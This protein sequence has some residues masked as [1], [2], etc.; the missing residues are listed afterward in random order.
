MVLGG[1]LRPL[2]SLLAPGGKRARLSVLIYHRVLA[3]PDA[4]L[5]G[6]P[7]AMRFRWQMELLARYFNP[8][9]LSEAVRR[10][11]EETLPP[12]AVSVT[13]DDGYADNM[14]IALP[15][16]QQVGV[17]ATFFIATGYLDGGWMWNDKIIETLRRMPNGD[18]D[19]T[20]MG[21]DVYSLVNTA[22]RLA[23]IEQ[24]LAWLKYLPGE[25]RERRTQ[26]LTQHCHESFPRSLMM[27]S[28]QVRQLRQA[29]M[30]IGAH[31]HSHPIL[32]SLEQA[33]AEQEIATSKA[34]LEDLLGEP[35][36]LFAYPNGKPGKDYLQEH[37]GITQ[38]LNFEAAV[39]T[40]WGVASSRSDPWQLPRFT[41]WD[42]TPSRF[43]VRLLWN[44]C[45]E[46][47]SIG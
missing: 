22:D 26:A 11:R 14:E 47:T 8:L 17:P 2:A 41:P 39:S 4:L 42:R 20:D 37:V 16:L 23:A 18:L 35:V 33:S 25:E 32:A 29:G 36:R 27:T 30:E 7:D 34:R 44:S 31:T 40:A 12:R 21:L 43:M 3:A 5:P 28:I 24:I 19:L 9:P 15:I 38:N 45:N 6:E 1:G 46:K 10:L 13:F